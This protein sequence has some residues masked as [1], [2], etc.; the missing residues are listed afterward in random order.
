MK[1][2][3]SRNWIYVTVTTLPEVATS[4]CENLKRWGFETF[5]LRHK[6]VTSP[7][8]CYIYVKKERCN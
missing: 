8:R 4:R 6:T 2:E 7:L 5:I 1:R 3:L